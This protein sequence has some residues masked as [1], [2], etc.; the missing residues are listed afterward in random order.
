MLHHTTES[1]L[2]EGVPLNFSVTCLSPG[3]SSYLRGLILNMLVLISVHSLSR[4][5]AINRLVVDY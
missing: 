2:E 4:A 3:G 1:V 5:A